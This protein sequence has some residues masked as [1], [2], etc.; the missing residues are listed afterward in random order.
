MYNFNLSL[1]HRLVV[2]NLTLAVAGDARQYAISLAAETQTRVQKRSPVRLQNLFKGQPPHPP[3]HLV[4]EFV[5]RDPEIVLFPA[6]VPE[7]QPP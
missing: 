1:V 4:P 3:H 2:G 7:S 6:A 5:D